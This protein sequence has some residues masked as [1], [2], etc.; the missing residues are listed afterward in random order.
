MRQRRGSKRDIGSLRGWW[1]A[2]P[3]LFLPF[4]VIF[5][6]AWLHT[7][8]LQNQYKVNGLSGEIRQLEERLHVLREEHHR[9]GR[10]ERMTAKAPDL[11]LVAP[12]PGQIIVIRPEARALAS[13][14][15]S[16]VLVHK[17]RSLS[18]QEQPSSRP[19]P[20][21]MEA[22]SVGRSGLFD[23]FIAWLASRER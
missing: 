21:L 20:V 3:F 11:A 15:M 8:I 4:A 1:K 18:T 7:Q 9:L 14:P 2:L 16:K 19:A 6:E 5:F 23:G 17:N 12:K 10:I 13:L 22:S